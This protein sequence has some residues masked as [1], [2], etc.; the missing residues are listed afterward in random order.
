[1]FY[2]F[3]EICIT[4]VFFLIL[5]LDLKNSTRYIM[6]KQNDLTISLVP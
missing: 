1:M 5:K 3:G 6:V 2:E 4:K